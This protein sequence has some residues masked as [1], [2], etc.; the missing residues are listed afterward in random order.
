VHGESGASPRSVA[1]AER[2][3]VSLTV[4][5]LLAEAETFALT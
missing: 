4:A 3:G 1:N 5:D 2:L